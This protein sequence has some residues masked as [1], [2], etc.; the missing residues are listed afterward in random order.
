MEDRRKSPRMDVVLRVR[1]Q[2]K[3]DLQEALIHNISQLGVYLATDTPF[4]VGYQF[5]IEINLPG[6][7][8]AI[9]GSCKV[10]WVNEIDA[11]DYPKGMGVQF[12]DLTPK[13]RDLLIEYLNELGTA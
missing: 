3:E 5:Q 13:D 7:K 1:F 2:S 12:I 6:D 4:D 10:I 8:G 9:N 11:E